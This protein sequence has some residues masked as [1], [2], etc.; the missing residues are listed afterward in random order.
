MPNGSVPLELVPLPSELV[1]TVRNRYPQTEVNTG[2]D[3]FQP[4]GT[5]PGLATISTTGSPSIEGNRELVVEP[6][7]RTRRKCDAGCTCGRHTPKARKPHTPETR[8]KISATLKRRTETDADWREHLLR[9]SRQR[10]GRQE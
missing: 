3:Q 2:R 6:K 7:R 4:V 5:D 9:I 8:A 1:G 10:T